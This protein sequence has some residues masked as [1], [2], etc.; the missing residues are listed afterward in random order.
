MARQA[1]FRDGQGWQA[2]PK[3]K[4]EVV[5][6]MAKPGSNYEIDGLSGAT[7]TGR[8]VTHLVQFWMAEQFGAYLV[9]F[10]K[11]GGRS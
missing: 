2:G 10:R 7:I 8:G 4:I 11:K 1:N 6:G 3:P 5:K 9:N